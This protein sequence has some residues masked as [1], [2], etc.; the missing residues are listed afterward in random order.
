MKSA[1]MVIVMYEI[2]WFFS[3]FDTC[4]KVSSNYN[5]M[6]LYDDPLNGNLSRNILSFLKC[7]YN[8]YS[9]ISFCSFF[10]VNLW[11]VLKD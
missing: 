9:T 7:S 6:F 3:Y 2:E 10:T 11:E 1:L 4:I 8:E 5:Q